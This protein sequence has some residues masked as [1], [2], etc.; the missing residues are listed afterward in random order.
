MGRCAAPAALEGPA[1]ELR[2]SSAALE[3]ADFPEAPHSSAERGE[4]HSHPC[5]VPTEDL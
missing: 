2:V 4:L 5:I 3:P 1:H